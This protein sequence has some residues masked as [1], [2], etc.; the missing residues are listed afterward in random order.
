MK[1]DG[2]RAK[3]IAIR[4]LKRFVGLL[5]LTLLPLGSLAQTV[6]ILN[7]SIAKKPHQGARFVG[8]E[9]SILNEKNS[10]ITLGN[11]LF[12]L[13]NPQDLIYRSL[14]SIDNLPVTFSVQLNPGSRISQHLWFE[15]PA[16]VDY[17][18]LRLCLHAADSKNW[19]DYLEIPLYST[20]SVTAPMLHLGVATEPPSAMS[21]A[22]TMKDLVPPKLLFAADPKLPRG[23]R[24]LL[25][26]ASG[27]VT[28]TVSL[29]VD[30][31]GAPRQISL[32][33]SGGSEFDSEAIRAVGRYRFKPATDQA[34]NPVAV[35]V[36]IEVT[37]RS[38]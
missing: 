22:G 1:P 14:S 36:N 29:V 27:K 18:T 15:V 8:V 2:S 33:K 32:F 26:N 35:R 31:Q 37:F 19:D 9:V 34:G 16:D 28:S 11:E 3:T 12:Y 30:R 10:A 13:T 7:L 17:N 20:N 4:L 24:E 23:G 6:A 38:F 21:Y 5:C 25:K